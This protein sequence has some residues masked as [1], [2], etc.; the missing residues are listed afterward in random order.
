MLSAE[1]AYIDLTN[2]VIPRVVIFD[3]IMEECKF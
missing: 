1:C 3:P 2:S